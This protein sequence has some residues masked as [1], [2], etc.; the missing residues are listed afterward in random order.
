MSFNFNSF[1]LN[2]VQYIVPWTSLYCHDY[3]T[4]CTEI[5]NHPVTTRVVD[6]VIIIALLPS[7]AITLTITVIAKLVEWEG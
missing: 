1:Q 6:M 7:L 3:E 5:F 4:G 2:T